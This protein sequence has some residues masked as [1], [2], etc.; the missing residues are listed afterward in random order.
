MVFK[1]DYLD[2]ENGIQPNIEFPGVYFL[3][4]YLSEDKVKTYKI[5]FM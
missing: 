1:Q 2:E 3:K 5:V 4:I